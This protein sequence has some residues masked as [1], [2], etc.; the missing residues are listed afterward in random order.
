MPTTKES[1]TQ[2]ET[3]TTTTPQAAAATATACLLDANVAS[4][5]GGEVFGTDFKTEGYRKYIVDMYFFKSDST[6]YNYSDQAKTRLDKVADFYKTNSTKQFMIYLQS[7]AK[8][9]TPT[10]AGI[11]LA[12]Q[13][14]EKS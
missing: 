3:T 7:M 4:L 14:T 12:N 2:K 8:D 6:E 11:V 10:S 9:A 13:R 5:T 1:T